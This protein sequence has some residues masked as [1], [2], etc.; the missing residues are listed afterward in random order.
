MADLKVL[1]TFRQN[2]KDLYDL[3]CQRSS[4]SGFIKDILKAYLKDELE[5]MKAKDK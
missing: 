2:E 3:I 4:K 5:K 1:V